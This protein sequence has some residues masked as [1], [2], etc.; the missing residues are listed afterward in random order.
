MVPI[1]LA[2]LLVTIISHA[3]LR[4]SFQKF[5]EHMLCPQK[6]DLSVTI[7]QSKEIVGH[8]LLYFSYALLKFKDGFI[9][10]TNIK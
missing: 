9:I 4:D 6:H 7:V 3:T 10:I 8:P 2:E 5:I 1:F